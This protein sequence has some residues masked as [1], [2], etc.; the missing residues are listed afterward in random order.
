MREAQRNQ[1]W[2]STLTEVQLLLLLQFAEN[3]TTPRVVNSFILIKR[4]V[5]H[6]DLNHELKKRKE[7]KSLAVLAMAYI[8][9][10]L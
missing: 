5:P 8:F 6:Q 3:E 1:S 2:L 10:I 7:N 9:F 4:L